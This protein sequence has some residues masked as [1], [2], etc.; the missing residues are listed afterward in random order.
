MVE[1][2]WI[3]IKSWLSRLLGLVVGNATANPLLGEIQ[4]VPPIPAQVGGAIGGTSSGNS[5]LDELLGTGRPMPRP[6]PLLN[7]F[8]KMVRNITGANQRTSEACEDDSRCQSAKQDASSHY[9]TLTQK[10][11]PQYLSGGTG[12]TMW[13]IIMLLFSAKSVL[14]RQLI[15]SSY[16]V[17]PCLS[18]FRNGSVLQIKKSPFFIDGHE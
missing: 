12:G 1:R 10:R 13:G 14:G 9:W 6:D 4:V 3:T 15:R 18:S 5:D 17:A 16:T 2:L 11:I 7:E 8:I